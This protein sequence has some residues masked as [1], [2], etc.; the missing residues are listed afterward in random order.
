[1]NDTKNK[2]III[3]FLDNIVWV[4]LFAILIIFSLTIEGF[5]QW[6]IFK[7]ILYHSVFVG[8]LAISNTLCVISGELDLST[9]SVMA[10]SGIITAYLAGVGAVQSGLQLNGIATLGIVILVGICVG[11]FNSFFIIKLKISSFII[12]L[13]GYLAFRSIGLVLTK[14][15][16]IYSIS[17]DILW[18]AR[19]DIGP[20]PL[21]VIIILVIYFL[22]SKLLGNFRL[23]RY[24]YFIGGN[25]Q[26]SYNAGINVS[27]VLCSVFILSSVLAAIAGWLMAGRLNGSS[28]SLGMG[29]LFDSLAALVIGGVSLKGGV[30]KLSGVFA[31]TIILSAIST[32]IAIVGM[33]PY[34]TNIIRGGLILSAVVLDSIVSYY[35]A[36]YNN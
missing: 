35:R 17:E 26:A 13:A 19:K 22:F 33:N 8:I 36:K 4:I 3:W 32:V 20:I 31:G 1:M 34:Y 12:T 28:P 16:G 15:R 25:R 30:G 11:V 2:K 7:N 6:S 14:G 24:I 10:L 23:G 18:V 29:M 5:N 21:M 27:K 9:E